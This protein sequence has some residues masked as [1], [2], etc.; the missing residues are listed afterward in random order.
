MRCGRAGAFRYKA[1]VMADGERRPYDPGKGTV[2]CGACGA[3]Y[4][5]DIEGQEGARCPRCKVGAGVQSITWG[6]G[7]RRGW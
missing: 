5:A 2:E 6:A 4:Y 7:E 3:W 1:K